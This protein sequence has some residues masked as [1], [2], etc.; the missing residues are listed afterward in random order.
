M[1]DTY[2]HVNFSGNERADGA[3][4]SALSLPITN[5]KLPARELMP[6]VSKFCLDEWEDICECEGN[7]LHSTYPTV[8]IVKHSKNIFRYDSVLLNRLRIGHSRL[9]HSYLL[10]GDGSPNCQSCGIPLTVKHILVECANLLAG[11]SWKILHGVLSC[12]LV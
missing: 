5:M 8:G 6:S 11:H 9:T 1:L 4:K 10:S 3:A 7:K 2:S 12:R